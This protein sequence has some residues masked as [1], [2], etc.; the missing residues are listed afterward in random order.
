MW[1]SQRRWNRAATTGSSTP[2]TGVSPSASSGPKRSDRRASARSSVRRTPSWSR[3]ATTAAARVRRSSTESA[4]RDVD[5]R[6]NGAEA[7]DE[8]SCALDAQPAR[9]HGCGEKGEAWRHDPAP[10]R[11]AGG[12]RRTGADALLRRGPRDARHPSHRVDGSAGAERRDKPVT[13]PCALRQLGR[14]EDTGSVE[15]TRQRLDLSTRRQELGIGHPR[16]VRR[17]DGSAQAGVR[18]RECLPKIRHATSRHHTTD[19]DV[20][21]QI[22][23]QRPVLSRTSSALVRPFR[24]P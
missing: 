6:G 10:G 9:S 12:D 14:M 19:I 11:R 18:R 15:Q 2:C 17:F 8:D 20:G 24:G 13:A 4:G 21:G 22:P 1:A 23:G 3:S 16:E 7:R 5:A